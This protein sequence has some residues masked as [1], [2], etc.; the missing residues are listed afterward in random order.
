MSI[1][2]PEE[3]EVKHIQVRLRLGD[4]GQLRFHVIKDEIQTPISTDTVTTLRRNVYAITGV[5]LA[6]DIDHEGTDYYTGG[7]Y[8]SRTGL[9]TLGTEL[10]NALDDVMI[11]YTVMEGLQTDQIEVSLDEAE[12]YVEALVSLTYDWDALDINAVANQCR[13]ALAAL[14]CMWI[15]NYPNAVQMGYNYRIGDFEVQTKLWGEGMIAQDLFNR[16]ELHAKE[17]LMYL[18]GDP[19]AIVTP[20]DVGDKYYNI[21]EYV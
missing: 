12:A 18:R 8:Q 5:Y 13:F 2:Y 9:L 1:L 11:T 16:L 4:L 20:A 15:L 17:L 7:S 21:I 10:S 14:K 19:H 3:E 6:T